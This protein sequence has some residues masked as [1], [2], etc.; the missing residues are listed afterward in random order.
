MNVDL[1]VDSD[2]NSVNALHGSDAEEVV[3]NDLNHPGKV[4]LSRLGLD[5]DGDGI[6]NYEDG[7]NYD[8][9]LGNDDDSESSAVDAMFAEL[10]LKASP[11]EFF[12]RATATYKLSYSASDPKFA[13]GP[14]TGHLRIWTKEAHESRNNNDLVCGGDYV[15]P[16]TAYTAEQLGLDSLYGDAPLCME[17]INP[18]LSTVGFYVDPDGPSG[19]IAWI[20]LDTVKVTVVN[21]DLIRKLVAAFGQDSLEADT[22][23]IPNPIRGC[24]EPKDR[25]R[26]EDCRGNRGVQMD[27]Q[28]HESGKHEH[29]EHS[30]DEDVSS[31]P[32]RAR[33][34]E[35][36]EGQFVPLVQFTLQSVC[37]FLPAPIPPHKRPT[38]ESSVPP[39][40]PLP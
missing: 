20:L 1:D 21:I 18:G 16:E 29:D 13:T 31:K 32:M 10:A 11:V 12:P 23:L 39:Q 6:P 9:T 3:E 14:S 40:T 22:V 4:I 38:T 7:H 8:G 27:K 34:L 17:G 19:P 25:E 37:H 36:Q 28:R 30:I 24:Q 5:S 15:A 35:F 26:S 33:M 2:N